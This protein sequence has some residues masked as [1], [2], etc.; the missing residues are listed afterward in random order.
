M[1][2]TLNLISKQTVGSAGAS[3]ITFSNIPQTY[4]DL[5]VLL[6]ARNSANVSGQP[7]GGASIQF[8]GTTT[9][10]SS[11]VLYGYG[12]G[13][14]GASYTD[15]RSLWGY[16][17]SQQS[18]AST[19]SNTSFYIPNYTSSNY[20]SVSIDSV[21]ENNAT[22]ANMELDAFLWA[23]TSI[24]SSINVV[25]RTGNFVQYSTAYLYGIKNS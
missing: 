13:L 11:R 9:N 7:F 18:T 5:Y 8:N 12:S 14:G 1:A 15:E 4:T 17:T 22:S 25:P 16:I 20:K 2:T 10:Y 3:S 21:N 19:F 24:I 23:N 6:S